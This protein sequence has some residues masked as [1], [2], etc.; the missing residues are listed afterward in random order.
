MLQR[1]K[2]FS[3]TEADLLCNFKLHQAVFLAKKSSYQNRNRFRKTYAALSR[4]LR[5]NSMNRTCVFGMRMVKHIERENRHVVKYVT[6][7]FFAVCH[8]SSE[9]NEAQ[10]FTKCLLDE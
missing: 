2:S 5:S 9:Q 8:G 3:T 6:S 7:V 1:L 4:H 10:I